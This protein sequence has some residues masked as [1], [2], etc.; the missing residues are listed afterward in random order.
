MDESLAFIISI[1]PRLLAAVPLTLGLTLISGVIGNLLAVPV[2]LARLSPNPLLWVPS[3][4]YILLMRGTPRRQSMRHVTVAYKILKSDT[5]FTQHPR[6]S[7]H[8]CLP[9]SACF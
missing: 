1:F 8:L 3:A 5:R 6:P 4:I 9:I 2:A 7:F